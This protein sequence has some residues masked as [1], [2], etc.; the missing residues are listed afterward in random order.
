MYSTAKRAADEDVNEEAYAHFSTLND[1]MRDV[2]TRNALYWYLAQRDISNFNPER[3][4]TT[5]LMAEICGHP[6]PLP[7]FW[8]VRPS[9]PSAWSRAPCLPSPPPALRPSCPLF[10]RLLPTA[11]RLGPTTPPS[12]SLCP[13]GRIGSRRRSRAP[14]RTSPT[15]SLSTRRRSSKTTSRCGRKPR[16]SS[17]QSTATSSAAPAASAPRPN[18]PRASRRPSRPS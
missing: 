4:P 1:A 7:T 2:H 6:A 10:P 3:F 8:K 18:C 12:S 17:A 13:H 9:P 11:A 14:P 16:T 15:R 5:P